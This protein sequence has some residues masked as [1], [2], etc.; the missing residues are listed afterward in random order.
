M[1]ELRVEDA[2]MYLDQVKMEF[3]DFPH[4]YNDFLEIMKTYKSQEIDTPVVIRRVAALFHGNK[5]LLLG[6]NSFLPEGYRI[7]FPLDGS[8]FPVY[9]EPGKVG[10][11]QIPLPG[12]PNVPSAGDDLKPAAQPTSGVSTSA[13]TQAH[14]LG[15][16]AANAAGG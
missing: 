1:R 10:V 7:E 6:F 4:I 2:L 3:G 5:R 14:Q 11:T 13:S 9:R 12:N 15:M 8:P 16:G